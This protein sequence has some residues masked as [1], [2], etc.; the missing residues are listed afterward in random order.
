LWIG[1]QR[2]EEVRVPA[3]ERFGFAARSRVPVEELVRW[4]AE[5]RFTSLDFNADFAPNGLGDFDDTR[6]AGVRALGDRSG[7][8]LALHS[9][10][11]VNTAEVAPFVSA[12][13]DEYLD[14]YMRLA[15][16]RN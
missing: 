6:A 13:V 10:S 7:V 2:P 16:R 15:A 14:A 12:A 5:H 4:A 8:T 9:S 11:A 3:S 1:V